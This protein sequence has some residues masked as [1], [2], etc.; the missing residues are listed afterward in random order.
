MVDFAGP[1]TYVKA[2]PQVLQYIYIYME[3]GI[4]KSVQI[5]LIAR[6]EAECYETT[7]CIILH[8]AKA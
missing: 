1:V 6:G 7:E 4:E 8:V 2:L 3:N 5:Q